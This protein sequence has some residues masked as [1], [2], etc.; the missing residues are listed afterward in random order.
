MTTS[1]SS[2]VEAPPDGINHT[3]EVKSTPWRGEGGGG[4]SSSPAQTTLIIGQFQVQSG[5][6]GDLPLIHQI[7]MGIHM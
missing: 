6:G 5:P 1:A 7:R 2:T 3:F 4:S